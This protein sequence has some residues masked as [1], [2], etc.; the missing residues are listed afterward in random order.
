MAEVVYKNVIPKEALGYLRRKK[1]KPT[2]HWA[3]LWHG[4]HARYFTVAR[5]V[6]GDVLN[7]IYNEVERALNEG[8]TLHDFNKA[9]KP[10]LVK[11]G[12]WGRTAGGV[13]L[14]SPRRLR[15][16]YDTNLRMA[17]A[18]GRW[19][20]IQRVKKDFPYL[21]YDA[22][23][24]GKTRPEHKSWNAIILPV[25]H[26][27]WKTHFPPN[28]WYCRCGVLSLTKDDLTRNGWKVSK[29]PEVLYKSWENKVTGEILQIPEGIE[30][31]FDYNV[32]I[33][34]LREKSRQL[35]DDKIAGF[36]G[37]IA[38]SVISEIANSKG[39]EDF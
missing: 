17:H 3:E 33:A 20:R 15:I 35:V 26:P 38:S 34:G 30:P 1:L 25:D 32:G 28:G 29:N 9:L 22:V 36:A 31:G 2:N 39:I 24:D 14:E 37:E 7:D 8:L 6:C 13:Q 18:A 16:I 27:F 10:I 21:M 12:W 23:M 4:E 5:S 19:E 11:K